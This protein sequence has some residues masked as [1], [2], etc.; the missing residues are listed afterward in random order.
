MKKIWEWIFLLDSGKK[1]NITTIMV[2]VHWNE[3]LGI[4]ALNEIKDNLEIIS[5]KVYL[6]YANLEAIKEN[7]R[8]VEKNLNRV[9]LKDNNQDS[10]EEIRVKEI[11]KILDK[12]DFLLDIHNTLNPIYSE[13][14]LFTSHKE[15]AKYFDVEKV[16][17]NIDEVQKW[18]SDWY[19]DNIWKK[20]FCLECGSINFW[21]KEKSKQFAKKSILN[22]LKMTKNIYWK[23]K[24]FN[25]EKLF[26]KMDY[27]YKIKTNNFQLSKQFKDFEKLKK[28]QLIAIDWEEKIYADRDSYILFAY[29]NKESW[30]EWFCIW[31]KV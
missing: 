20:G 23:A 10:Y 5:W 18:S 28:S 21:D 3:I 11:L 24:D 2:W 13:E 22:F 25:R 26:L 6:V 17:L 4:D 15:F 14:F 8:F 19:V 7:V 1:G 9:F 16:I 31:Y 29:S 27:L 30:N 12:T